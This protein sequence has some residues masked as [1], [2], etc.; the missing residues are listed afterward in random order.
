LGNTLLLLLFVICK[1]TMPFISNACLCL[2]CGN[3]SI[4]DKIQLSIEKL[5]VSKTNVHFATIG[6]EEEKNFSISSSKT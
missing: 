1:K 2:V 5:S 3:A 4:L 6:F